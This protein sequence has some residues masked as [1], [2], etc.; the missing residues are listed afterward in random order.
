MILPADSSVVSLSRSTDFKD[1]AEA[2]TDIVTTP[3]QCPER[4][5]SPPNRI[6]RT[7]Q[8]L[9][10]AFASKGHPPDPVTSRGAFRV[11]PFARG[12]RR[13]VE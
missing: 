2:H 12:R 13:S 3:W 4:A 8:R 5:R 9:H 11:M 6:S 7:V 1:I 10:T